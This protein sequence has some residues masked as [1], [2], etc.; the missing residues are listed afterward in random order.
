MM[1]EKK[2]VALSSIVAA[3]YGSPEKVGGAMR[4]SWLNGR[5]RSP[6]L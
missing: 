1:K 3:F 4:K 6:H 5:G 2:T